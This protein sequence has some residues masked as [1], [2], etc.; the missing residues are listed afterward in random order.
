M[1]HVIVASNMILFV[2]E[3]LTC[4]THAK[5]NA[6]HNRSKLVV[7]TRSLVYTSCR[8]HATSTDRSNLINQ[9]PTSTVPATCSFIAL[10]AWIW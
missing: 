2:R 4:Q 10:Q 1:M 7:S 8:S 5:Q 9:H 3:E 6:S